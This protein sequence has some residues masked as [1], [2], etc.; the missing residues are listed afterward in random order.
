MRRRVA[1][2]TAT[3]AAAV[4]AT[5]I[6]VFVAIGAFAWVFDGGATAL[7]DTPVAGM[8][9][10][11]PPTSASTTTT[12]TTTSTR[13][14]PTLPAQTTTTTAAPLTP[15]RAHAELAA[16]SI[17]GG[18][19]LVANAPDPM[20]LRADGSW[21]LYAT[22]SRGSLLQ[23]WRS[24]DLVSWQR[25]AAPLTTLPEWS[26]KQPQWTWAPVVAPLADGTYA[27]Y[28]TTRHAATRAQCI[29]VATATEPAGPFFDSGTEPLLCQFSLGG[30]IDPSVFVEADGSR[31]LLWKSDG[32]CCSQRTY[33]WSQ[34]LA[35]DGRSLVGQP[36]ALLGDDR[37]WEGGIV[38]APSM[39]FVNGVYHLVN[40]ANRWDTDQY[41]IGQA[42][43]AS[44][45][46]PCEKQPGDAPSITAR[47]TAVAPGGAEVVDVGGSLW[48]VHHT[49]TAGRVGQGGGRSV[50]LTQLAL[51][52]DGWLRVA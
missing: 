26:S 22:G 2:H 36:V 5:L 49:W 10:P 45:M 50:L 29:S 52:A 7:D 33:L 21:Y 8:A 42:I 40:S 31:V 46:G 30:S 44:A 3:I 48:I 13:V 27:M 34:R 38:E 15:E 39:W 17:S 12:T 18:P 47:G 24:S 35:A 43:C 9:D 1:R 32:N 16:R 25:L 14:D 20:L 6:L 37:A 19:A 41:G 23:V 11:A 4:V 28:Y 51:D